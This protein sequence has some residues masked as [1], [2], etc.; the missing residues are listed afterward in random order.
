MIVIL[1]GL[2]LVWLGM[3]G[4]AFNSRA[5]GFRKALWQVGR[6]FRRRRK[7]PECAVTVP[8]TVD[9]R[10]A[11]TRQPVALRLSLAIALGVERP[12]LDEAGLRV[13]RALA[14]IDQGHGITNADIRLVARSIRRTR[15]RLGGDI[16]P[17]MRD[18]ER[19]TDHA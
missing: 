9:N 10:L 8:T 18:V 12:C 4:N 11:M 13:V 17:A 19:T 5:V 15:R 16:L 3:T 6:Q 7:T 1:P 2:L 14:G